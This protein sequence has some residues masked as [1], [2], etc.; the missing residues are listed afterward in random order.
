MRGFND[1]LRLCGEDDLTSE[2]IT[3]L[4][5]ARECWGGPGPEDTLFSEVFWG[6]E[7]CGGPLGDNSS[8]PKGLH[9][10]KCGGWH[11]ICLGCFASKCAEPGDSLSYG[12]CRVCPDAVKVA[13]VAMGWS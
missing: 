9:P 12:Q 13:Y 1:G 6:C 7:F 3:R 10:C 8:W 4:V 2:M 11:L 5:E